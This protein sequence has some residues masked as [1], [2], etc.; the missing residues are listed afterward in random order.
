MFLSE[1]TQLQS[2]VGSR[3]SVPKEQVYPRFDSLAKLCAK[4][5]QPPNP[6]NHPPKPKPTTHPNHTKPN[7]QPKRTNHPSSRPRDTCRTARWILPRLPSHSPAPL[8]TLT[9]AS[10]HAH[11]HP[12]APPLS[13]RRW[14]AFREELALLHARLLT[15]DMLKQ[16]ESSFNA[17]LKP[18][19][20][21]AART[22]RRA[23]EATSAAH[24]ASGLAPPPI[25]PLA[26]SNAAAATL[27]AAAAHAPPAT[28]EEAAR[29]LT[30]TEVRT[31]RDLTW[32]GP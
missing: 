4:P 22:A 12:L 23:A 31:A 14:A 17:T 6:T 10:H 30:E 32:H 25:V 7:T 2:L 9:R 26:D 28:I 16:F 8:I 29:A 13:C 20:L 3:S 18:D 15:L 24:A 27:D 11:A 19:D 21:V 5:N 1:M